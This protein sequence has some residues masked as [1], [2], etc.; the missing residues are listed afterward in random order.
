MK[1]AWTVIAIFTVLLVVTALAIFP[2]H[3]PIL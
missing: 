2:T 3:S 1:T